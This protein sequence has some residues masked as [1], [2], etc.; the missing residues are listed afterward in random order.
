MSAEESR[1]LV[2]KAM[3]AARSGDMQ[4]AFTGLARA[5]KLDPK[6]ADAYHQ[7]AR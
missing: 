5:I 3:N 4:P 7:R 6:N 2:K 1:K